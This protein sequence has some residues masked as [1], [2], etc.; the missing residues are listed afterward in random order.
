NTA[1]FFNAAG[2]LDSSRGVADLNTAGKMRISDFPRIECF[3]D[4]DIAPVLG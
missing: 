2:S 4:R 1:V 3:V